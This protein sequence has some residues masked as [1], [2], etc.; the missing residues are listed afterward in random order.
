MVVLLSGVRNGRRFGK[1]LSIV[2]KDVEE[3]G[4][5]QGARKI[6]GESMI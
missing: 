4:N 5:D 6:L 1:R 2:V 3:G